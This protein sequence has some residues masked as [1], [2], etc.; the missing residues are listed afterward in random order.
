MKRILTAVV[1]I[2]LVLAAVL[3]V[4]NWLF[5]LLTGSVALLTAE[6]Y[7]KIVAAHGIPTFRRTALVLLGAMF[8]TG[9]LYAYPG[10]PHP[11]PCW[12]LEGM[13]PLLA[14]LVLAMILLF[15]LAMFSLS[16]RDVLRSVAATLLAFI[17]VGFPFASVALIRAISWYLLAFVLLLVWTG[18]ILAYFVGRSIGRHYMAP[19]ISPKKTW[20]GAIASL[21]SSVLV[22]GALWY[23]AVPVAFEAGKIGVVHL[24]GPAAFGQASLW[25]VLVISVAINVAAQLG[26]LAESAMKRGAEI[27][28]S[29]GLLPGHGGM[30]DRV[31]A[32]LFAAPVAMLLFVIFRVG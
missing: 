25:L 7:L 5:I 1:L 17:Y 3:W 18:D 4:P 24:Y 9:A 10:Q 14:L 31:D 19:R 23:V 11:N 22:G 6:E 20:E 8:A 26:D 15:G 13:E 21:L 2:P 29:G 30:L 27:K 16:L 28:D 32:L 12:V